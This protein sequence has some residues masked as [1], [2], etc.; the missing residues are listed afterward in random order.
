MGG[1][2]SIEQRIREATGYGT[3]GHLVAVLL[4]DRE[5]CGGDVAVGMQIVE[6]AIANADYLWD[7]IVGPMLDRLE[8]ELMP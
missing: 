1:M 6:N 5:V 8:K 4:D 2:K 7:S 3:L